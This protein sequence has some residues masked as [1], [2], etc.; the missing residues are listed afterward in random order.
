MRTQ[1]SCLVLCCVQSVY[2]V[3]PNRTS[4]GLT[5]DERLLLV[6]HLTAIRRRI[7]HA[8]LARRNEH[9]T[10]HMVLCSW[11]CFERETVLSRE[12]DAPRAIMFRVRCG[13]ACIRSND[14]E[15]ISMAYEKKKGFVDRGAAT[16]T[17]ARPMASQQSARSSISIDGA[18][19]AAS[20]HAT[21][22]T[23]ET[24]RR[25]AHAIARR[26]EK[27]RSVGRVCV[28]CSFV[29]LFAVSA[30]YIGT[31]YFHICIPYTY[32]QYTTA[33]HN[34]NCFGVLSR[35]RATH[36]HR[37]LPIGAKITS[38]ASSTRACKCDVVALWLRLSAL[39]SVARAQ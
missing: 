30:D 15:Y 11:G 27:N 24:K 3:S 2:V 1:H 29:Y 14:D 36:Q 33:Q 8:S 39:G 37:T 32:I 6:V 13:V 21:T 17:T 12:L 31:V 4:G 28:S 35:V 16:T 10:R 23:H 7:V 38:V 20:Q 18:A 5:C 22:Y 25:L 26:Q 34:I 9:G 19:A